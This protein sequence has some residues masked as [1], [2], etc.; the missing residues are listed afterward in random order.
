MSTT[1]GT[2]V[3]AAACGLLLAGCSSSS[4]SSAGT[5]APATSAPAAAATSAAAPAASGAGAGF[6]SSIRTLE[7]QLAGG[8]PSAAEGQKIY[9]S[10]IGTA[11]AA[12]KPDIDQIFAAYKKDGTKVTSDPDFIKAE[13]NITTYIVKN[14][15]GSFGSLPTALPSS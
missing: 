14:C 9:S 10:I 3:A 2:A 7:G 15:A 5:S 12:V 11:P 13:T 4:K 6:C 8:V 1:R